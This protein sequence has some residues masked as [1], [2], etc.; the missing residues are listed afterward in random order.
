MFSPKNPILCLHE[1]SPNSL[2]DLFEKQVQQFSSNFYSF[3]SK[4]EHFIQIQSIY[5]D[6]L[7]IQDQ[8]NSF[9]QD[10]ISKAHQIQSLSQ[11][12]DERDQMIHHLS[13]I[14]G[15]SFDN[16]DSIIHYFGDFA[17][18]QIEMN[19]ISEK[20]SCFFKQED[21]FPLQI[22][23][24][25]EHI[26]LYLNTFEQGRK[27][28]FHQL[29]QIFGIGVKP[30]FPLSPNAFVLFIDSISDKIFQLHEKSKRYEKELNSSQKIQEHEKFFHSNSLVILNNQYERRIDLIKQLI[31][32]GKE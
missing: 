13:T 29:Y 1:M 15:Q 5:D 19:K 3:S 4:F 24:L 28:K 9:S 18:I 16:C 12:R 32:L 25:T 7:Q 14:F 26:L 30:E 6:L 20:S 31:G 21:S 23:S 17:D 11:M 8:T 2:F 22:R 10:N 27:Q